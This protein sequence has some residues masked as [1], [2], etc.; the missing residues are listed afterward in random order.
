MSFF[1]K[2]ELKLL[3]PFYF[4]AL[5]LSM[6]FLYPIFY[7]LYFREIGFSLAQIGFL[8]S[9]Y[10]LAMFLFEI[11]T[12]AIA[13]IWGRKISTILGWFLAGI[14]MAAVMF[15]TNFYAILVLFFIRGAVLTLSSGARDAW[16]VDLLKYKK[17][18]KLIHEFYSKW[19]SFCSISTLAAG[20]VGA[21][22]VKIFGLWIIWPLTG[23][24][25]ILTAFVYSFG[26]EHFVKSKQK[27]NGITKKAKEIFSHS[28]KSVH[29]SVRHPVISLLLAAGMLYW[30]ILIFAGEIVWYPF[31]Q[32]LGFKEY[33]FG[34]LVSASSVLGIFI[35]YFT[36][37]LSIKFGGYK[38]YIIFFLALQSLL[39]F[40]VFFAKWM[41]L[42]IALYIIFVI[43]DSFYGPVK[44]VFFQHFL[45]SKMRATIDSFRSMLYSLAGIIAAPLA[46]FIADNI[47][48]QITIAIGGLLLIP[49]IL[50]Y[51]KIK[52]DVVP[53]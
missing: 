20:I 39:L 27:L 40:S 6:L 30:F 48:P 16:M 14:A 10:G 13:D 34:Y 17:R 46:G 9:A 51:L 4:D 15:T 43:I 52:G 49:A 47:G 19:Q 11:P 8:G 42:A 3:W 24:V 32:N 21:F 53:K 22:L 45:P 38:K 41:F 2:G 33:W 37:T 29:Y 25:M 50:L 26:Q 5:F 7:I 1:K 36:K 31:L 12:G 35:P 28:I 44:L 18:K 23:S